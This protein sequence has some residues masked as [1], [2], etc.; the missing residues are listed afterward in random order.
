M[1]LRARGWPIAAAGREVGVSRKAAAYW[2]GGYKIYGDGQAAGFVD[3]LDSLAVRAISPDFALSRRY[4]VT[5]LE[6]GEEFSHVGW[7][8]RE[9]GGRAVAVPHELLGANVRVRVHGRAR[10]R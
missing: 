3:P 10:R 7:D 1:E 6:V 5:A 8:V 2:A 4:G 9:G